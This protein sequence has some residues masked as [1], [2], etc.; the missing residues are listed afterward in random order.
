[1]RRLVLCALLG[2]MNLLIS[3]YGS[4]AQLPSL[5]KK[6]TTGKGAG[7]T[8]APQSV[9]KDV[10]TSDTSVS[11][12]MVRL[13]ALTVQVNK[14]IIVLKRGF[15]TS[16]IHQTVNNMEN[17]VGNLQ[18]NVEAP[19]TSQ[20]IR[21]LNSTKV[22]MQQAQLW[23][24]R[25]QDQVAAYDKV[26]IGISD[27]LAAAKGDSTLKVVP[28]DSILM[29][30]YT[31][32][33]G[34][35]QGR[36]R[37]ADSI[38]DA[39]LKGVALLQNRLTNVF[40]QSSEIMDNVQGRI[41]GY[42]KRFFSRDANAIWDRPTLGGERGLFHSVADGLVKNFALALF[43]LV[44]Q[45][46]PLLLS[47]LIALALYMLNWYNMRRLTR[48]G[49]SVP[50][51]RLHFIRR[52]NAISV[53]LVF[54]TLSPFILSNPPA[55]LVQLFWIAVTVSAVLLR[56][57]DWPE[58]FR[59]KMILFLV[60]FGLF[61]V[62]SFILQPSNHERIFLILLNIGAAIFGWFMYRE[63]CKDKSRYHSLMDESILL[64]ILINVLAIIAN[65][66]GRFNLSRVLSNSSA[67][68]ISLLLALQLI[69]EIIL[70]SLY[71]HAETHRETG[72][73]GFLDYDQQNVK[74]RK[75]L[76]A[77][78]LILWLLSFTWSL[79]FYDSIYEWVAEFLK[80]E[81]TLGEFEFTYGSILVFII[82]IWV[83]IGLEKLVNLLLKTE[84]SNIPGQ[85]KSK[86]GSWILFSKLGIYIAGFLIAF[87]AAGL[88]MD[89]LAI[90]LG[91]LSVG[92]GFGLQNIVNNLVSGIILAIEKP[93]EIG[94]VIELGPRM[95]TV[96]EIG[97]R[98]SQIATY[99]GSVIIV[100][101]GD[102]ISQQLINWTHSNN[103]Y[104]RVDLVI[105]APYGSDLEKVKN[106]IAKIIEEHDDVAK[107]PAPAVFVH[108]FGSNSVDF[109][110]LFW[111]SEFDKFVGLK[112]AVLQ[113]IYQ[114]FGEEGI[115]IPFPQQ[116][117]HI[118]SIDPRVAE[119]LKDKTGDRPNDLGS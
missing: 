67:L 42:Q 2:M 39:Q 17:M 112:S 21:N 82:V 85:R 81:R 97:F 65:A 96:K 70:E 53:L 48:A 66:T 38:L 106:I 117:L 116:D 63:A 115:E 79:N 40:M 28:R 62:D 19:G 7:D 13:E 52:S 37:I 43:F 88:G 31:T 73:A 99:D 18:R 94:D 5:L 76:G 111:T 16:E 91:A 80:K 108:Q 9:L 110:V 101:N 113:A 119:I 109:R 10:R 1:M 60:F 51:E 3:P 50:L 12:L 72:F 24:T 36:W 6:Q 25:S 77:V 83:T 102:F 92:I 54:F 89:K 8:V 87:A 57:K 55:G 35:L 20:N 22:A 118:R 14:D 34:Q 84:E 93:M 27:R 58:G 4:A 11:T 46:W 95:G 61:S 104:R 23:M 45:G 29:S 59:S 26:L 107:Y 74:Y 103:N 41:D 78:T 86:S 75:F 105:G 15:D 98:S 33:L 47:A 32:K 56:W 68:S 69:R 100:P 114:R 44:N 49:M 71:L 64:F 90:V 30:A